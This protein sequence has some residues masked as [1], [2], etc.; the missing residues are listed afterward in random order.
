MMV[1]RMAILCDPG[2]GLTRDIGP[3]SQQIVERTTFFLDET[4]N[5]Q[6]KLF[7]SNSAPTE[8]EYSTL[9]TTPGDT[10]AYKL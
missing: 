9:V 3:S 2:V 4:T 1:T 5:R 7:A 8:L 6:S 10:S